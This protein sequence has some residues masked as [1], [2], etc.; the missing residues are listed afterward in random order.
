MHFAVLGTGV[1][2]SADTNLNPD[3]GS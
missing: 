1:P 2:A 3:D